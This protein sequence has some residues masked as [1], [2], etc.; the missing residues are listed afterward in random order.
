[1]IDFLREIRPVMG[2]ISSV[3]QR[4]APAVYEEF[5]Q[6]CTEIPEEFRY[7]ITTTRVTSRDFASY[8]WSRFHVSL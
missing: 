7:D 5:M 3:L 4:I 6:A 1:V 8:C 2:A